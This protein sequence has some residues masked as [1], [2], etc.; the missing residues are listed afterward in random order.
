M[1]K[2]GDTVK[3][4]EGWQGTVVGTH[5]SPRFGRQC[6]VQYVSA[7]E[8]ESEDALFLAAKAPVIDAPPL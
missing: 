6:L 8:W 1:F 7:R 3:N 2:I 4:V 5:T